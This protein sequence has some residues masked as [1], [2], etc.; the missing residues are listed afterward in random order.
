MLTETGGANFGFRVEKA[1]TE[2]SMS[3]RANPIDD[4]TKESFMGTFKAELWATTS[5]VGR[6][7][8]LFP[9]RST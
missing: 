7:V 9:R 2:Q 4:A 1:A 3:R 6:N 5:A 8:A